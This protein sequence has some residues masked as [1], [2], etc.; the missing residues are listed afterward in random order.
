M[1][2]CVFA[3][4]GCACF[5]RETPAHFFVASRVPAPFRRLDI[6]NRHHADSGDPTVN[7]TG[8]AGQPCCY[9]QSGAEIQGV[10]E[11]SAT[12]PASCLFDCWLKSV[13]GSS[14][15]FKLSVPTAP[16]APFPHFWEAGINSPHSAMTLRADWREHMTL[17]KRSMG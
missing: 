13:N 10:G 6:D 16:R 4:V 17:L 5:S 8:K 3:L 15:T 14:F 7:C 11:C 1:W 9:F 2:V 12:D